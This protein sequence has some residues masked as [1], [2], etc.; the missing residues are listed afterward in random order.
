MKEVLKSKWFILATLLVISISAFS[1]VAYEKARNVC[2]TTK[3]CCHN[4]QP[5]ANGEMLWEVLS[6][7]FTP[8][9]STQ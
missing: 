9:V 5:E 2:S 6:H 3:D 4:A 1:F 8:S 7:Q